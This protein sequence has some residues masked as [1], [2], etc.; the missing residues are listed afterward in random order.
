MS[1]SYREIAIKNVQP[2]ITI[3]GSK[4]DR[5]MF[6]SEDFTY[7]RVYGA[8]LPPKALPRYP[9]LSLLCLEIIKQMIDEVKIKAIKK[10]GKPFYV[11]PPYRFGDYVYNSWQSMIPAINL[12]DE[13]G[14]ME[15]KWRGFDPNGYHKASL[16]KVGAYL[17]VVHAPDRFE[18]ELSLA[19]VW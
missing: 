7:I 11:V 3:P 6:F 4:Y 12:M 19:K 9:P 2:Y 1:G 5:G 15:V 13:Y 10:G 8:K 18:D 16:V 14:F 17:R